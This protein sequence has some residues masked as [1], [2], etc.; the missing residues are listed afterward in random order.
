LISLALTKW[1]VF[2]CLAAGSGFAAFLLFSFSSHC[3][4]KA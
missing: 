2:D 3:D 1:S 4:K